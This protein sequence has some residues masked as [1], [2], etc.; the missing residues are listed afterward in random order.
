MIWGSAFPVIR[1]G[2]LAG[3]APIAF[4]VARFGSATIVMALIAL[5]RRE[6]PPGR[7]A[8]ALSAVLGGGLLIGGYAAFLYVGEETISGGLASLL[9]GA[10]PLWSVLLS[11]R[12]LP[13]ERVG[14]LGIGGLL[15]GFFGV[16]VL[17]LPDLSA[18]SQHLFG[19]AF[20]VVLAGLSA[21][22]A[23]VLLRR[24]VHKPTGGW[25]LTVEFAGATAL[26]G[27][28]ALTLPGQL[29][30]PVNGSTVAALAYLVALPSIVGYTIYFRLLNRVGPSRA[31]LV[32]Y[33]GPVAGVGIGIVLLGE[34]V[35]AF[36]LAGFALILVGLYLVQS[37]GRRRSR[38]ATS[39]P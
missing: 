37:D 17:F 8:L 38:A 6:R 39:S 29:E 23:S 31:N 28:L 32:T 15:L 4:G 21:A 11:Y 16:A 7:R 3:A 13:S 10:V 36:E 12:L 1:L 33:V 14:G 26:L 19:P 34:S 5:G 27:L 24:S 9:V 2:L 30:L 18:A 22:V 35:S 25:G 20:L